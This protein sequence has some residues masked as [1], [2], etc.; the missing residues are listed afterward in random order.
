MIRRVSTAPEDRTE[1]QAYAGWVRQ[2]RGE[3]LDKA[4]I[5]EQDRLAAMRRRRIEDILEAARLERDSLCEVW[6]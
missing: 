6:E 2:Y 5:T 4:E 3:S 1:A